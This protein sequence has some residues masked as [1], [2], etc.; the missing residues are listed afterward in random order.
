MFTVGGSYAM[1][2]CQQGTDL[3]TDEVCKL[4]PFFMSWKRGYGFLQSTYEW[5][6]MKVFSIGLDICENQGC[7][8]VC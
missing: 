3:W 4:V 6:G 7:S 1:P 8:L 2:S 5:V